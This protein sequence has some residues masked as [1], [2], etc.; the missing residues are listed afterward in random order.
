MT[1]PARDD[2]YAELGRLRERVAELEAIMAADNAKA[3]EEIHRIQIAFRVTWQQAHLLHLL[4]SGR[5]M[6]RDFLDRAIAMR[7]EGCSKIADVVVCKIRKTG[8][9]VRCVW[10][11]G[12][13][14][15]GETLERVRAA[16]AGGAV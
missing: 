9:A 4:S 7:S 12:Y 6:Q 5:L 8:L 14:L 3:T 13:V 10:G 2:V 15:E 16:M 11:Q 1:V